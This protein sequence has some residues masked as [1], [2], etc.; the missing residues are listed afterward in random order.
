MTDTLFDI[1]GIQS[2]SC[3]PYGNTAYH[4]A[5][6]LSSMA[7]PIACFVAF[8]VSSSVVK[9]TLPLIVSLGSVCAAYIIATAVLSP[10]P[11]L[12]DST[13]GKVLIV[14]VW[15]AFTALFSYS[16]ACIASILR[17]TTTGHKSLFFCGIFTQIGST[18][19]AVLMF[20]LLNTTQIFNAY[21][22]CQ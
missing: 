10:E 17:N 7:N 15:I 14:F 11:P 19:G 4:L 3:L 20:V 6:T 5:V 9:R 22:P 12:Q 1:P 13:A 16:R 21:Y 2:Y 8:Y 18:M